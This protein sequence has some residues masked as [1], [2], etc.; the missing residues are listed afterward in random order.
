MIR[1][2]IYSR[3]S[4][5]PVSTL[6][7]YD[8]IGLFTA[9]HIDE[10][11]GYRYYTLEQLPRIQRIRAL[12][13]MGLSLDEIHRLVE[14]DLSVV[15]LRGMLRLK[16]AEL[17]QRVQEE[18]ERLARLESWLNQLELEGTMPEFEVK[19]KKVEKVNVLS[20]R[21]VIKDYPDQGALWDELDAYVER[22]RIRVQPPGVTVY[23]QE[24]PEIDVEV[25]LGVQDPARAAAAP[26]DGR[27]TLRELPE[28]EAAAAVVYRGPLR[29]IGDGYKALMG[30]V[31]RQGYRISGPAREV[32]LRGP[33]A[34]SQAD[35]GVLV[36][37]Q[38]PVVEA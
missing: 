31:E 5:T 35:P 12:K 17:H 13:E 8:E 26:Q 2:G 10:A 32:Y 14:A 15:E 30:W 9:A 19:I 22:H 36:E 11:N 4:Q 1:I 7:Y 29:A 37:L 3:I 33:Q 27:V 25:C 18:T 34:H 28:I 20:I 38:A 6:R 24:E 16:Q 21:D 23:Y